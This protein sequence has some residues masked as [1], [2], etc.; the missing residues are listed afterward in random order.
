MTTMNP[1]EQLRSWVSNQ[2][3]GDWEHGPG[4]RLELLD[5]PGWMLTVDLSATNL[6]ASSV[7]RTVEQRS[8]S[9]WLQIEVTEGTFIGCGGLGNLS[10]IV[11]RFLSLVEARDP[12]VHARSHASVCTHQPLGSVAPVDTTSSFVIQAGSPRTEPSY[13][14]HDESLSDAAQASFPPHTESMIIVWNRV[15]IPLGYKYDVS[16][17]LDDALDLVVAMTTEAA[18][19]RTVHWPSTSFG[20][21][22]TVTWAD[23]MTTIHATWRS[24]VGDTE[25]LLRDSGPIAVPVE[26]FVAEWKRPFEIIARAIR[27][28]GYSE[29]QIPRLATLEHVC[30]QIPR[31]GEL[32][33]GGDAPASKATDAGA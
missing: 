3:N 18:S 5:N 15:C 16:L 20:A 24:I 27:G 30:R 32:Y 22:W 31:Y 14:P 19:T 2:C 26:S 21:S 25:K 17:V 33:I 4:L 7:V 28:A 23:S 8:H 6:G 11:E 1:L 29:Q 13:D 9:D 10:E 12:Q